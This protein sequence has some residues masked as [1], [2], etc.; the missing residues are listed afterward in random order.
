VVRARKPRDHPPI[1]HLLSF[2]PFSLFLT[3]VDQNV[4]IRR[5]PRHHT[6]NVPV[7]LI[8]LVTGL[9]GRQKLAGGL[10]FRGQDNPVGTEDA[11]AG[12]G[13]VDGLDGVLHLV[14]TAFWFGGEEEREERTEGQ[15]R[16]VMLL[17][18]LLKAAVGRGHR[19]GGGRGVEWG[20]MMEGREEAG[21]QTGRERKQKTY[22]R[23]RMWWWTNRS[24]LPWLR[25][26]AACGVRG[27][28]GWVVCE[29][30]CMQR[31]IPSSLLRSL[32]D[33]GYAERQKRQTPV[34]TTAHF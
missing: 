24:V 19:F 3:L 29:K 9:G 26:V 27:L 6:G 18:L 17:P 34:M 5:Q 25:S 15:M 16:R 22:L 13:V 23:A 33:S 32:S 14:Q 8:N 28:G 20:M 21:N 10:S 1:P 31:S 7:N 30:E 2:F 11:H 4:G 12:P